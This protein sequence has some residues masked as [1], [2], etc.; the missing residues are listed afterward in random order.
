MSPQYLAGDEAAARLGRHRRRLGGPLQD[1]D[2][3]EP[4]PVQEVLGRH[5]VER[6]ALVDRVHHVQRPDEE[7]AVLAVVRT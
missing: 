1:D 4:L 7:D 2:D 3:L 5:V 6:R